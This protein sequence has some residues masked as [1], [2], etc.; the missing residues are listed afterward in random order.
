[1]EVASQQFELSDVLKE[2]VAKIDALLHPQREFAGAAD[3][4]SPSCPPS[5]LSSEEEVIWWRQRIAELSEPAHHRAEA[6]GE[7]PPAVLKSAS[8]DLSDLQTG[9]PHEISA[10][11]LPS[12]A[13][14]FSRRA[15]CPGLTSTR[16]EQPM[17]PTS[18]PAPRSKV[19]PA[20]RS[21]QL[22]SGHQADCSSDLHPKCQGA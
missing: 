4:A 17:A 20:C 13:E 10:P 7:E 12:P 6:S 19:G 11:S 16:A 21:R 1:D 18:P 15:S 8:A 5:G 9:F 22:R 14:R 2:R 3:Q